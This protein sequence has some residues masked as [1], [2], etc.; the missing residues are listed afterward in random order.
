MIASNEITGGSCTNAWPMLTGSRNQYVIMYNDYTKKYRCAA[1]FN[2]AKERWVEHTNSPRE[3]DQTCWQVPWPRVGGGGTGDINA[4]E[5]F[6]KIV[7]WDKN[8]FLIGASTSGVSDADSTDGL[9]DNHCYSV[10]DSRIDI[11]GTGINLLLIRN[12]WGHGGELKTG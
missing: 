9:I 2:T 6:F 7:Q 11:C 5:L 3:S 8:N 10:I 12:P 1:K 4:D